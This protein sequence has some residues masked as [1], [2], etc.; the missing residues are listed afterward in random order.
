MIYWNIL[1]VTVWLSLPDWCSKY[2]YIHTVGLCGPNLF[3]SIQCDWD[4]IGSGQ[5][6]RQRSH[7]IW[8]FQIRCGPFSYE[9]P[10]QTQVCLNRRHKETRLFLFH[11][12]LLPLHSNPKIELYTF[13]S[14]ASMFL[15]TSVM[16][17]CSST[18][19][20]HIRAVTS[21]RCRQMIKDGV[22]SYN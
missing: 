11:I 16:S 19:V 17:C 5:C 20:G 13:I 1:E 2:I 22:N 10:N 21:S 12:R 14:A 18:D 9:V 6:E 3:P 15:F 8:S 7:K 4:L